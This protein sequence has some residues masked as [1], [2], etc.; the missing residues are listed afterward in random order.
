MV[1]GGMP[2]TDSKSIVRVGE[3]EAGQLGEL[4]QVRHVGISATRRNCA[5][6]ARNFLKML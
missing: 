2:T 3:D 4:L 5:D 1:V 6:F